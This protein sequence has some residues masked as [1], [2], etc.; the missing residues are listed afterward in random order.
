VLLC[1][2]ARG[3]SMGVYC[4]TYAY[5]PE[6][7]PTRIRS[8]GLGICVSVSKVASVLTPFIS[9][10]LIEIS[11]T[12]PISIFGALSLASSVLVLLLRETANDDLE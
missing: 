5:T 1:F 8:I 4:A 12:I 11:P 6:L 3:L 7:Y 2:L 10:V 9:N